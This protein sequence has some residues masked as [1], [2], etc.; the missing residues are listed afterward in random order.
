MY[1]HEE[2]YYFC[3]VDDVS[4]QCV[5][6]PD[7]TNLT[8]A[9]GLTRDVEFH[10]Q[11]MDGNARW[12]FSNGILAPTQNLN[13]PPAVLYIADGFDSSD[14]GTYTCSPSNMLNDPSRDTITLSAGSEYVAMYIV[15]NIYYLAEH[16]THNQCNYIIASM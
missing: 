6:S 4:A 16:Y 12:L 1:E 2:Y 8:I 5:I 7:L 3:A 14:A 13:I 15:I 10:C 9:D 11:C